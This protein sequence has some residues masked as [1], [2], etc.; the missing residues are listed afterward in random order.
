[1]KLRYLPGISPNAPPH[2][3]S[4]CVNSHL[5]PPTVSA[6]PRVHIGIGTRNPSWSQVSEDF[7]NPRLAQ[8]PQFVCWQILELNTHRIFG[9]DVNKSLIII[10]FVEILHQIFP[11]HHPIDMIGLHNKFKPIAKFNLIPNC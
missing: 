6:Q 5:N 8:V 7:S 11:N 3:E 1:M 4:H 10:N 9:D 2:W